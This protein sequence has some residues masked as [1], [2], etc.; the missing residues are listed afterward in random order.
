MLT[1]QTNRSAMEDIQRSICVLCVDGEGQP[2]AGS[3]HARSLGL[4]QMLHGGGSS[5]NSANRFFDKIL[6]VRF[7]KCRIQNATTDIIRV[8]LYDLC[9]VDLCD[10]C[11]PCISL[12]ETLLC[13][14]NGQYN[15]VWYNGLVP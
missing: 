10:M 6:Q 13:E 3:D 8:R 11:D 9:Q 4:A 15:D 12:F 1:D 5:W 7:F 2:P 14:V